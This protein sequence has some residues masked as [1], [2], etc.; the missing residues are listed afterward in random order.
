MIA[1][2]AGSAVLLFTLSFGASASERSLGAAVQASPI[3]IVATDAGFEAPDVV[4][5]GLRHVVFENRGREIHEAMLVKL[6]EGMS[7]GDYVNAVKA[8]ALF[9]KGALDYAGAGLTAPGESVEVWLTVDPGNYILICWNDAHARTTAVHPFV[10]EDRGVADEAPPPADAVLALI[11]Y[12]FELRGRLHKGVQVLRVE[13]PGPSMHEVDIFRLDDGKTVADLKRWRKDDGRGVAPARALGG[14]LDGH[15]IRRVTWLRRSF[16]S[17]HY[18]FH[19]EMPLAADAKAGQ[20]NVTHDDLGMV[21][22][23]VIED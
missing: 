4:A 13:T 18:A 20:T 16:R 9:P 6:A 15:D 17:G 21:R 3:R 7:A 1:R 8:G 22:E 10:V 14:V 23:F 5:A 11:D 12:R 2:A 19:C